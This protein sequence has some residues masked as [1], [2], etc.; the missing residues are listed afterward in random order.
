MGYSPHFVP[1]ENRCDH[2]DAREKKAAARTAD[3]YDDG[4]GGHLKG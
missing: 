2:P 3:E 1:S 4:G